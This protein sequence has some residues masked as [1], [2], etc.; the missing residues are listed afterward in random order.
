MFVD[1]FYRLREHGVPISPTSFLRLQKALS[2]GLVT[3]LNDF[4]VVARALMVK[5]ERH[6]DLYDQL[7]ANHF[8]GVELPADLARSIELMRSHGT[9]PWE[10][11]RASRDLGLQLAAEEA[12][13]GREPE[14][15]AV[16]PE[17]FETWWA[18]VT[19]RS[20]WTAELAEFPNAW[21]GS[22]AHARGEFLD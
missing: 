14:A 1:F 3:D 20:H 9:D 10:M 13:A 21:R 19:D 8:R 6:F 7:F 12:K 11:A 16:E 17:E 2:E 15:R 4:Y 18:L 5:R 22:I